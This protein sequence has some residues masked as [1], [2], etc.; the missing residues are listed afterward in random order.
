MLL[1]STTRLALTRV[2]ILY[3]ISS[4]KGSRTISV[5]PGPSIGLQDASVYR[6]A[7]D[8]ETIMTAIMITHSPFQQLS[9]KE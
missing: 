6:A 4:S 3:S 5:A 9:F 2:Y 7:S 1:A 8:G